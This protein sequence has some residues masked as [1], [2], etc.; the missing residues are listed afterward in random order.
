MRQ[1][2]VYVTH[3]QEDG[4]RPR[5]TAAGGDEGRMGVEQVGTPRR[6]FTTAPGLVFRGKFSSG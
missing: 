2:A 4:F 3:D 6:K 1:T 5:P